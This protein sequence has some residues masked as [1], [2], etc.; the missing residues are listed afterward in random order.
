MVIIIPIDLLLS[1]R[2]P[3]QYIISFELLLRWRC[4]LN[5]NEIACLCPYSV[6][7]IFIP[8]DLLLSMRFP[9]QYITSLELLLRWRRSL[10][11]GV[12]V[13]RSLH[14]AIVCNVIVSEQ[15]CRQVSESKNTLKVSANWQKCSNKQVV[16]ES[17]PTMVLCMS[18]VRRCNKGGPRLSHLRCKCSLHGGNASIIESIKLCPY[19]AII[20]S[21]TY[22]L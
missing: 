11:L 18:S 17:K 21:I 6:M 1:M 22:E 2:F 10:N 12:W 4:S 16:W 3:W 9:W 13:N 14:L 15:N 8:I 7:V 19:D 5:L 20:V